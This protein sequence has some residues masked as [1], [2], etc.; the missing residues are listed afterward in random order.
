MGNKSNQVDQENPD[1]VS[2]MQEVV[3]GTTSLK[4]PGAQPVHL[5][6]AAIGGERIWG[7]ESRLRGA[8]C[9]SFDKLLF[10]R[11]IIFLIC[12]IGTMIEPTS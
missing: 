6:G 8:S 1:S 3:L 7:F 10:P 2:L 11:S 5:F 12:S 9:V 4:K